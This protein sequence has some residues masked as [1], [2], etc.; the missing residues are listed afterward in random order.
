[1]VKIDVK[2]IL[3]IGSVFIS[4]LTIL[5]IR[6]LFLQV[7]PTQEVKSQYRNQQ[8]E[9]IT[10]TSFMI[11]DTNNK[12][13]MEYNKKYIM[14]I[15]KKPFSLNNYEKSI[16]SLMVLNFIMKE[17]NKDFNYTNIMKNE[18]KTYFTISESTYNKIK[19]I[20]GIKGVYT[21]VRDEVKHDEAWDIS[22]YIS[23]I[24]TASNFGEGT[25][26]KEIKNYVT[27]NFLPK[28]DFYLD[29]NSEYTESKVEN[30][31]NN[32]N[33]KLTIDSQM[34]DGIREV[35]SKEEFKN[36]SNLGVIVMEADT[37]K[38]RVMVQKDESQANVNLA[39]EGSGYEP[40]SVY[41]LITLGAALDMGL[42]SMGD[43]FYCTGKVCSDNHIH[44]TIT[45]QDALIKSCNDTF[46]TIGRKVGYKKLMEYSKKLG[47]FNKVLNLEEES[48][49]IMP[50]ETD[51]M[52]N[53]SIGQCLTV[54]PLQMLAATNS[55]INDGV[56]VKPYILESIL[57]TNDNEIKS[58]DTE[59]KKVFSK[60]TSK[61]IKN[62]MIQV[63]KK[64]TGV[65]ADVE[66]VTIGGKT[67]S[68]TSGTG[69]TIHGWF[70]G[71]FT[72]N[73][74]TYSMSV[75]VPNI[76]KESESGEELGGGNTAAPIFREI[77]KNII[78]GEEEKNN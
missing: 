40:G 52:D 17:E 44:G 62:S 4:L 36:L 48:R 41:K 51:G 37:G 49:G 34:V 22:N 38:I 66:G 73:D 26:N 23:R 53:I 1:M 77:V 31:E 50:N 15:D 27:S 21:Y 43:V 58:L 9:I 35:I 68:A 59:S 24:N 69:D 20:T 16:E 5:S 56:Y 12:D 46:A 14:V 2:R 13:L 28:Q 54:S 75:F 33:I 64:G 61:I 32:N 60:T 70:I 47:I 29:E 67:G 19:K 3:V 10:D 55:I 7:Y 72:I 18:G 71:Y 25:L 11:L 45:L 6:L 76:P 39:I 57:D 65:N 8:S 78:G 42:E 30:I 74:K 63:V